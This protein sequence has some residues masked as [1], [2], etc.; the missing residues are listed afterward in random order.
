[1][2][3]SHRATTYPPYEPM[4]EPGYEV[5]QPSYGV[6]EQASYPA[7]DASEQYG[8]GGN[9]SY[10]A[11]QTYDGQAGHQ[12]YGG[13]ESHDAFDAYDQ[14]F[15]PYPGRAPVDAHE[16]DPGHEQGPSYDPDSV[17][18]PAP[19]PVPGPSTAPAAPDAPAPV[20]SRT[21]ARGH[22]RKPKKKRHG[23]AITAGT[24]LLLAAAAGWYTVG[25]DGAKPGVTAADGPG[26]EG[27]STPDQPAPQAAA[28]AA[29]AAAD[30]QAEAPAA[31]RSE[32]RP[33]ASVA[34]I[35]GLGAAFTARIPAETTQVV[36]ASGEDKNANKN[37]VT[38][39]TRTPEGRWLAGETWHGHNGNSGWTTDHKEGDLRSP[40]G[41]FSLTDAGGRKADPGGK[42][43]YDKDPAFVV[44]GTG[45][46]G[47][48]LEGSFDY[49]VAINYNRVAGNSPLDPRRP[50][51]SKKGGGIWIHVDHDGPTHGCVS[52]PEDKMAELIRTLDPAAHPVIVMGDAASLAA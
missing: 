19:A 45:F 24:A 7:Y 5:P 17:F 40:I 9:Q 3:G 26:P 42:L 25:Q 34:A 30:R 8:T 46:F 44:S 28:P 4:H 18:A 31:A 22:R 2:S 1:M 50:M 33:D 16:P 20:G 10:G 32:A 15:G 11:Y 12:G 43:P 27:V 49:V 37:T 29:Q 38:L 35:P 14:P 41:V 48:Q 36:L 23:K 47:D 51:G 13:Y 52:I 39:W 21:A 6:Y